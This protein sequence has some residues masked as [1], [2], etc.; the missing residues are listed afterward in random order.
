M[1]ISE[2]IR[3]SDW[4]FQKEKKFRIFCG[5]QN[6]L[7][8]EYIFL[9]GMFPDSE[10][11]NPDKPKTEFVDLK[12]KVDV[13]SNMEILAGPDMSDGDRILLDALMNFYNMKDDNS[14]LPSRRS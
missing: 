7:G 2:N 14:K 6:D 8:K 5:K 10:I 11:A 4:S 3:F 13:V 1:I 12:L 9:P